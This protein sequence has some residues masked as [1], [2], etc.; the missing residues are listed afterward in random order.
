MARDTGGE[1]EE[2]GEDKLAALIIDGFEC[3]PG[4]SCKIKISIEPVAYG[5]AAKYLN[6]SVEQ[7]TRG[8]YDISTEEVLNLG[9]LISDAVDCEET[10]FQAELC[11]LSQEFR[12][13][14]WETWVLEIPDYCFAD[15]MVELFERRALFHY[16]DKTKGICTLGAS[17][18]AEEMTKFRSQFAKISGGKGKITS[19]WD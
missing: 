11:Q 15:S 9:Q 2:L 5:K 3:D 6:K 1:G 16:M 12:D 10:H 4:D 7:M 19:R 8:G 13:E 17:L 14:N 18:L